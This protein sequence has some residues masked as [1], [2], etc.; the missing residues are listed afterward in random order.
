MET[1]YKV[2]YK[3][4]KESEVTYTR[5]TVER[6]Y[7]LY[8]SLIENDHIGNIKLEEVSNSGVILLRGNGC[9]EVIE[10]KKEE[11]K[12]TNKPISKQPQTLFEMMFG[13]TKEE[14]NECLANWNHL[15]GENVELL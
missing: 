10:I 2:T 7:Y 8:K 15:T 11:P 14:Y 13:I 12:I 9:Y 6:G 1:Y 5:D 3:R 4:D